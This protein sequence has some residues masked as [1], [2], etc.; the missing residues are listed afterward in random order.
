ML[1]EIQ[2]WK[3][4]HVMIGI[5]VASGCHTEKQWWPKWIVANVAVVKVKA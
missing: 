5:V 1:A 3:R 2:R 4:G